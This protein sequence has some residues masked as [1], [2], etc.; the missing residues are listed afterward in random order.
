MADY[1]S[2]VSAIT[3]KDDGDVIYAAHH[4]ALLDEI[5]ATQTELGIN[6]ADSTDGSGTW[7]GAATSYTN[8]SGRLA[9]IEA[10]VKTANN[11]SLKRSGGTM[12]GDI[13]MDGNAITGLPSPSTSSEPATKDY[14]DAA[15]IGLAPGGDT[16]PAGTVSAYLGT[17][18]P[19]GWLLCNGSAV[20]RTTYATL[21]AV[22]GS[23]YGN[24][25]GSS[26]F[27]LPDFRGK[28]I[29]GAA[30]T[31]TLSGT[32]AG[33]NSHTHTNSSTGGSGG[34]S[35]SLT[36]SASSGSAG[37]HTH[38][39]NAQALTSGSGGSHNHG[40]ATTANLTGLTTSSTDISHIHSVN[41]PS[42]TT[43]SGGSH[44]HGAGT[45]AA[46][47]TTMSAVLTGSTVNAAANNTHT[48]DVTGTS[49][50]SGSHTHAF[51]IAAFDSASGGSSHT[52]T[53]SNLAI[54]TESAHT[55]SVSVASDTTG[56]ASGHTH[57]VT[58]TGTA[59]SEANHTH[60]NSDTGSANNIPVNF[61]INWIVKA[62]VLNE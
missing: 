19:A 45:Y 41:P 33:A 5:K 18:A 37:S 30:D 36:I 13:D 40:G 15:I 7:S 9:N 62:Q 56:S 42:D 50:S 54:G 61:G 29:S 27:N 3:N 38:T 35:H 59:D 1:P 16:T 8:V 46:A 21:Y 11:D 44:T 24:G 17:S 57:S 55:H 20:S 25:D 23:R 47:A 6:P 60:T 22:I 49:A 2:S 12:T 48:H 28:F 4:N 58:A 34:H 14:V 39:T 43:D 10:G 31:A 26:T 52:H 53:I 51:N 32:S